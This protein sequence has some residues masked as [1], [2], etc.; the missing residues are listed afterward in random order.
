MRHSPSRRVRRPFSPLLISLATALP[1]LAA[2]LSAHAQQP[3]EPPVLLT[4]DDLRYDEDLGI[5][6]ATG[7]VELARGPRIL[8]ADTVSYSERTDVVV[9]T[10]NVALLEP[11]GEVIFADYLELADQ[12]RQG[13]VDQV[14]LLMTDNSRAAGV[15][16]ERIDGRY[17]RLEQGV[18]SPCTL[19]E[20]DPSRA[21]LWQLRAARVT[22]DREERNVYYRDAIL[23]IAGI[24]VAYTPFFSH[25]DATVDR[26]SGFLAPGGGFS[27]DLGTFAR[28]Y[29]YFDLDEDKDFTLEVTP[30]TEDGLLL[31]GEYRQF[32]AGGRMT[33]SGSMTY[34]DR[35]Q[36]TGADLRSE[37]EFRGHIF[38]NGRFDIDNR[39][40]W[41][42]DLA[43]VTDNTHLR[44][45]NYSDDDL[46]T[47]R[48]FIEQF[49]GR[50]YGSINVYSFQDL[51]PGNLEEEPY[52]VP[53][54][55]YTALGEP[56]GMLGGRWS[57]GGSVLSLIRGD[58]AD[59]FRGSAQMG[60][61]REFVA[62]L[63]LVSTVQAGVRGDAYWVRDFD[64]AG[65]T[66][67]ADG[68]RLR[69]FP[70][71]QVSTSL[72]LAR[73]VGTVQ[74]LIEPIVALTAAPNADNDDRF[75][76]ED[77]QD[78]E[79]DHTNLFLPSRFPGV[80][81]LEGGQRLTY[82]VRA[83]LFGFGGGSSSLFLG[84]SYRLQRENDFPS[85][86]GLESRLS[87]VVGRIEL[88]PS[89]WLD[90]SYSFRLDSETLAQRRHDAYGVFGPPE[91]RVS[92]SYL[93][94]NRLTLDRGLASQDREELTLGIN[95]AIAD[96]WSVGVSHRRDLSPGG[97]PTNTALLLTYQDECLTFQLVGERDYTRRTGIESGDRI[98]FRLVFKNLGEFLSPELSGDV[99][100]GGNG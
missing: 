34:A 19:C 80:D 49:D 82:G 58:G 9:A 31:G 96:H 67:T 83:G 52:V 48:L 43:R 14:R 81:R 10:G 73:Q 90:I 85:G 50:D 66:D 57:A 37:R 63:G 7:N 38:G 36:G 68:G 79:F 64:P 22:H 98:F 12:M 70:Q 23:E 28:A 47:S 84:Q 44:R 30:S 97:G 71:V 21:P 87:D 11:T 69:L 32:I 72:P 99:F 92:G 45:Y 95:S 15:Q 62:D 40:R 59:T 46:L 39:R 33:L 86:S 17:L 88:T 16:A 54:A 2:G 20:E 77:S 74:Q 75:P 29:Y 89:P 56:D 91:F 42:F 18:Y 35:A 60:W 8:R 6:T 3:P 13:F 41:G 94:L 76:N 93:Y 61:R 55:A 51:R 78:I 1:L 27:G 65:G 26:R 100:G 25:P 4:A 53:L 24:P 5:I